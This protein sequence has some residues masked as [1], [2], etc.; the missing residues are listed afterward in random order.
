MPCRRLRLIALALALLAPVTGHAQVS[1]LV[2]GGASGPV[3]SLYDV[4]NIGY[5]GELGV[6]LF[7]PVLPKIG[8]RLDGSY[9]SFG[10]RNGGGDI[11]IYTGT[12]NVLFNIGQTPAPTYALSKL[13]YYVLGGAGY[14]S[15]AFSS[16]GN[17]YG[18]SQAAIGLNGGGG[19]RYPIAGLATFFEARYH[20]ML[21]NASDN[22]NFQFVPVVVGIA[23]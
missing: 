7:T 13:S 4:A 18:P 1:F 3:G 20:I 17:G 5:V 14:Y 6:N 11:R 12:V 9:G 22:A 21:G 8:L 2:M 23:F 10:I 16:I 19:L 15:R